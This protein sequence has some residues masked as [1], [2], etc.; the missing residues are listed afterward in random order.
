MDTVFLNGQSIRR[1][2]AWRV[3]GLLGGITAGMFLAGDWSGRAETGRATIRD[4]Q[5]RAQPL[6]IVVIMTD[7][8]DIRSTWVMTNVNALL[9]KQG[10]T[11]SNNF[12][13]LSLCCPSRATFLT[14]QYAHN[15]G[16]WAEVDYRRLD[17]SNTLAVW[18]QNG[19][20]RTAHIGKYLNGYGLVSTNPNIPPWEEIPPG[21]T[22]WYGSIDP[23]TYLYYNYILNE[24]GVLK[25]YGHEAG[26]YQTD[27]YAQ[28]A[29][30][31]ITAR[32]NDPTPFF[33]YIA[34]LAPHVDLSLPLSTPTPAPRHQGRF[35]RQ[36][37]PR[38]PS[39]NE[40][41]MSDKPSFMQNF[42][43]L[44]PTDI[45]ALTIAYRRRLE[46]LLA[47][48][49]AVERI[50]SALRDAGKLD[51]TVVIY[52]SD[53]GYLLG[54]HRLSLTKNYIYEEAHRVPLIIRVPGLAV[55]RTVDNL[56]AN[57]D[58]APTVVDFTQVSAGRVMD[59]RSLVPLL[60][61][62]SVPWRTA[63]LLQGD[64]KRYEAIRTRQYAYAEH[65]LTN[66]REL[67]NFQDDTCH[68]ADPNQ[69][70]SQ[71]NNPCYKPTIDT[72][73]NSLNQLRNCSGDGCWQ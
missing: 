33:L 6:N 72:L 4:P 13:S 19:G 30:T 59:G 68:P 73:Q 38:P 43:L 71:H 70:E 50:M 55:G 45:H 16:V 66:E 9:A 22:E 1:R 63:L 29:V 41:D 21:W 26:N 34:F 36:P 65:R 20:Y 47:V 32:K 53:N 60:T 48:D 44:G 64:Y 54:P 42:R 37:L 40:E 8:Q 69:L 5:G 58:L 52:T 56:V 27:V 14:G 28:K 61:P 10:T 11:F 15:H 17:H 67:Y 51:T 24:N 39:F 57:V 7:D 18:L 2:Q 31:F 46:A 23:F 49:D 62:P 3:I 35:K 12:V 25:W